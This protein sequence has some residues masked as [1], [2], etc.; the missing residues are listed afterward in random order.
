MGSLLSG[1]APAF[2]RPTELVTPLLQRNAD[3]AVDATHGVSMASPDV[4]AAAGDPYL[5]VASRLRRAFS[6]GRPG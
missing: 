2:V 4:A 5:E 6:T 3:R 1:L